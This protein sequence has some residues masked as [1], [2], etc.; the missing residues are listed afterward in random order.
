MLHLCTYATETLEDA[1]A[2][3]QILVSVA[4]LFP[5]ASRVASVIRSEVITSDHAIVNLYAYRTCPVQTVGRARTNLGR[6]AGRDLLPPDVALL[7]PLA[8][9]VASVIRSEVSPS[10]FWYQNVH[11]RRC[12]GVVW[13]GMSTYRSPLESPL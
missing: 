1:V 9:Q 2:G 5:L 8:S 3:H 6:A 10:N 7:I 11:L 13:Y 12:G 4:L